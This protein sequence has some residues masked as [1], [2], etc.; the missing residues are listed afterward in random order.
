MEKSSLTAL[1]H[2]QL[3][4]ARNASSGNSSHTVYGGHEHAPRHTG[5]ADRRPD[6]P[7][8]ENGEAADDASKVGRVSTPGA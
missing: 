3:T 8:G 1:T 7:S 6:R 4:L 2:Q 5:P